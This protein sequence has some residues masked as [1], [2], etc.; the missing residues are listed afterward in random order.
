MVFIGLKAA[1]TKYFKY[2]LVQ[3]YCFNLSC[4]MFAIRKLIAINK[5]YINYILAGLKIVLQS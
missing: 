3:V 1:L 5:N 4:S 2:L